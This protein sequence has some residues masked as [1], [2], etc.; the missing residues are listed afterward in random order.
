M[1]GRPRP[2]RSRASVSPIASSPVA[3]S[4]S[5]VRRGASSDRVRRAWPASSASSTSS[6]EIESRWAISLGV[7]K[8]PSSSVRRLVASSTFIVISWRPRG[9]AHVPDVVAE[10]TPELAEDRRHGERGEPT[11]VARVEPVDGLHEA[12]SGDL[13]QVVER[14]GLAPVAHRERPRQRHEAPHELLP[15]RRVSASAAYSRSSESSDRARR[16]MARS[17]G[18]VSRVAVRH[19][20]RQTGPPWVESVTRATNRSLDPGGGTKSLRRDRPQLSLVA[21]P[22]LSKRHGPLGMR[23][24][25]PAELG[26]LQISRM[27]LSLARAWVA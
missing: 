9:Q 13:D 2:G 4:S 19:R 15:A 8:R 10:V 1:R 27:R 24:G 20:R 22:A 7:G 12:E 23:E 21:A 14:L 5:S 26:S 16:G 3:A 17:C 18:M 25:Y 11:P 6:T